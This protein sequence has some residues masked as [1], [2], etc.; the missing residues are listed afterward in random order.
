MLITNRTN[1]I[2][3]FGAHRPLV[4]RISLPRFSGNVSEWT[5][6][7][8]LFTSLI[9]NNTRL[10]GAEK[11][12][13]LLLRPF[14]ISNVNYEEAWGMLLQRYDNNRLII[15][16]HLDNVL[17]VPNIRNQ[18]V[19]QLRKLVDTANKSIRSL[20]VLKQPVDHWDTMAV[21]I[22]TRKLDSESRRQWELHLERDENESTFVNFIKFLEKLCRAFENSTISRAAPAFRRPSFNST[23]NSIAAQSHHASTA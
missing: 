16:K 11:M 10:S 5:Q 4:P 20:Q 2:D 14:A 17:D 9:G 23:R 22:L 15:A 19:K 1:E 7:H 8:D 6:F 12:H 18:D 21:H 13:Q 3:T